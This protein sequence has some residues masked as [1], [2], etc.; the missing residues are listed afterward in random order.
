VAASEKS[1][2]KQSAR[3]T[4]RACCAAYASAGLTNVALAEYPRN[5]RSS[6]M[7]IV[8]AQPIV[9]VLIS[10]IRDDLVVV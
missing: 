3:K 5:L 7:I 8:K 2:R 10:M 1:D 4:L 6:R 9:K